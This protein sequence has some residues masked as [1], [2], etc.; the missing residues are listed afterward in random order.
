[1]SAADTL[2]FGE[3]G[4]APGWK[5]RKESGDVAESDGVEWAVAFVVV[6]GRARG[7]RG[8]KL[9]DLRAFSAAVGNSVGGLF[10]AHGSGL[11]LLGR[12]PRHE[13]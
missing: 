6:L 10:R 2:D 3:E 7:R 11:C 13:A 12:L 9:S 4:E 1:M 8:P 5:G